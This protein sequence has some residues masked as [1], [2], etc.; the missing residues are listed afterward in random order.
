MG[1]IWIQLRRKSLFDGAWGRSERVRNIWSHFRVLWNPTEATT[2]SPVITMDEQYI[3]LWKVGEG[4]V[5]EASKLSVST[6][7]KI[8][9]GAWSYLHVEQV[10]TTS[11]GA[12]R[13]WDLRS[14]KYLPS[15]SPTESPM[16]SLTHTLSCVTSISTLRKI[17]CS[18]PVGMTS[19]PNFGIPEKPISLWRPSEGILIG[20]SP[21]SD[22]QGHVRAVSPLWWV[23]AHRRIGWK[24][25]TVGRTLLVQ[26]RRAK[27]PLQWGSTCSGLGCHL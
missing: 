11:E 17:I 24:C 27:D 9:T 6:S 18:L 2:Q 12:V 21:R 8:H 26:C 3:R 5:Q 1:C 14:Y 20:N 4:G 10:I 22:P 19:K 15:S 16:P 25:F 7:H 13:G 23:I